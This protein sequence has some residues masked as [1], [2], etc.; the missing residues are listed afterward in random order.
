MEKILLGNIET[1]EESIGEVIIPENWTTLYHGTNLG[2]KQWTEEKIKHLEDD[3]LTINSSLSVISEEDK[4]KD[5]KQ[6][7]YLKDQGI[8]ASFDTTKAYSYGSGDV[9]IIKIIFPKFGLM[10]MR[11]KALED[12]WKNKFGDNIA[13][14]ISELVNSVY[15]SDR[16]G[17]RHP[18][19]PG[20]LR[21]KKIKDNR[22]EN[23]REI[24]YIP[25]QLLDIYK[26]E[27]NL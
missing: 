11:F 8:S 6:E 5:Q 10:D 1:N 13:K 25:E 17:G 9:L 3:I 4:I 14:S 22:E 2:N 19:L 15:F 18:G 24:T 23:K 16:Y 21:L 7:E 20:G 12:Y 27:I 26:T